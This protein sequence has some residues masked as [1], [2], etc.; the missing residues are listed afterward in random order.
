L[1]RVRKKL[2]LAHLEIFL[3]LLV[4]AEEKY[5]ESEALIV[6]TD[7]KPGIPEYEVRALTF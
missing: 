2:S 7:S 1:G 5:Q 4:R 6:G 3:K